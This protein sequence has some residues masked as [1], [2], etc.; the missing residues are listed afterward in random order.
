MTHRLA[1]VA[2][3]ARPRQSPPVRQRILRALAALAAAMLCGQAGAAGADVAATWERARVGLPRALT[4]Q[5]L[6]LGRMADPEVA[7]ALAR[8]PAG[9]GLPAVLFLH[10]CNG[11]SLEEENARLFLVEHGY[12]VFMPDSFARPGR[13]SNCATAT[14]ATALEPLASTFRLEEIDHAL[15]RIARLGFVDR[16]FL[17]GSS[18]GGLAVASQRHS[19]LPLAGILILAWHC[20]GREPFVGVKAAPEVP[21]LAI[22]GGDDPWYRARPGRHCG[23]VFAG[24]ANARSIVLPGS[25]HAIFGADGLANAER[26]R[27]AILEFL[28]A[29]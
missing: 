11:F 23:E 17:A 13:Q 28:G 19:P 22:I 1:I 25:G 20:Q 6:I 12:P 3:A 29:R 9:L 4:G 16:V 10:G 14:G 27:A 5:R 24:R 26:A 18:E 7:A 21:V 15:D 2:R 8:V